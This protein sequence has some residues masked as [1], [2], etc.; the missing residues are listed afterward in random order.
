[1]YKTYEDKTNQGHRNSQTVF[2]DTTD[3][4]CSQL[5]SRRVTQSCRAWGSDETGYVFVCVRARR[6]CRR[7][8][9]APSNA[10]MLSFHTHARVKSCKQTHTNTN[11]PL[12]F[13]CFNAAASVEISPLQWPPITQHTDGSLQLCREPSIFSVHLPWLSPYFYP[14]LSESPPAVC[15]D[16]LLRILL[17]FPILCFTSVYLFLFQL[18]S[19]LGLSLRHVPLFLFSK[20][21]KLIE[22]LKILLCLSSVSP[23]SHSSSISLF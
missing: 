12:T 20:I 21:N 2:S 19:L 16:F 7:R 3:E 1:M 17:S 8:N 13:H 5:C 10:N 11:S 23:F 14:R 22:K 15:V 18:I 4:Y 9:V 6:G